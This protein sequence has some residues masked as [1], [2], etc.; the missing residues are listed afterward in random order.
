[1]TRD[2]GVLVGAGQVRP[3]SLPGRDTCT[4]L[5]HAPVG[6][7]LISHT[8]RSVSCV[9]LWVCF[10][11]DLGCQPEIHLLLLSGDVLLRS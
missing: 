5:C 3:S 10:C 11:R 2:R 8:L 6:L 7:E 9:P 1:M 4:T